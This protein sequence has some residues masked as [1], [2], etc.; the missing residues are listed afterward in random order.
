MESGRNNP[1]ISE[2]SFELAQ[3][4][5]LLASNPDKQWEVLKPATLE[6][7]VRFSKEF[8]AMDQPV[9]D[10]IIQKVLN[11]MDSLE[12]LKAAFP[13]NLRCCFTVLP[14][15]LFGH[16]LDDDDIAEGSH[17]LRILVSPSG[18]TENNFF[19]FQKLIYDIQPE[20]IRKYCAFDIGK[21]SEAPVDPFDVG[22]GERTDLYTKSAKALKNLQSLFSGKGPLSY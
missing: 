14:C 22:Q 20:E 6:E 17:I 18:Q 5:R 7:W 2:S 12:K 21:Y 19:K 1:D 4:I 9:S 11:S 10:E 15:D 13:E 16:Q 3:N 8:T